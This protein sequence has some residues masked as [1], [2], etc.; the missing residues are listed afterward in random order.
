M[1]CPQRIQ[2]GSWRIYG[3]AKDDFAST[4]FV[5][6][7]MSEIRTE[8]TTE[9]RRA[10]KTWRCIISLDIYTRGALHI[11][12]IYIS[13]TWMMV[14]GD[15]P[16]HRL[17]E[18]RGSHN[19][20]G[21]QWDEDE[22]TKNDGIHATTTTTMLDAVRE[23]RAQFTAKSAEQNKFSKRFPA[24]RFISFHAFLF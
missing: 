7:F 16:N 24:I 23:T 13:S 8:Q 2:I 20:I 3:D 4:S 1:V 14:N 17:T 5:F 6:K 15:R 22:A 19:E 10:L 12:T 11:G 9:Q 21:V 18:L